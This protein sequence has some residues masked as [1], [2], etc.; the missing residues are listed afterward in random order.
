MTGRPYLGCRRGAARRHSGTTAVLGD[1][2]VDPFQPN[3]HPL[4]QVDVSADLVAA[5]PTF[6]TPL[7]T[8]SE[9]IGANQIMAD[10]QESYSGSSV[11]FRG[12]WTLS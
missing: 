11:R 8:I 10:N 2:L 3:A 12:E 1:C 5:E 6:P 9:G 7:G 4:T